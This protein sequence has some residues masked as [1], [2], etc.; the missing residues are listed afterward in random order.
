MRSDHAPCRRSLFR[1]PANAIANGPLRVA[2]L[3]LSALIVLAAGT[4]G[5]QELVTNGGFDTGD[6]TGYTL[7]GC[8][9][10]PAG[11]DVAYGVASGQYITNPYAYF[12][13]NNNN[14]T[15]MSQSLA[16]IPGQLYDISFSASNTGTS[17]DGNST[18]VLLGGTTLFDQGLNTGSYNWQSF[19]ES[20]TATSASTLL[21]F[22]VYNDPAQT[23]LDDISVRAASQAPPTSSVPEPSSL[24]LLG[25]GL[26]GLIPIIR[27]RRS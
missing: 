27:K 2:R 16:T 17:A 7:S 9:T 4:A 23:F 15:I 22:E 19:T 1:Q 18:R 8:N 13:C 12:R 24:A 25:S 20:F 11:W 10:A 6:F 26:A 14:Y 5:A 3:G 21:Q